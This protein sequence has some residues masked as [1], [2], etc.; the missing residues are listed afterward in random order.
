MVRKE[1]RVTPKE[2]DF[3]NGCRFLQIEEVEDR[4]L[5]GFADGGKA[6]GGEVVVC[7]DLTADFKRH[8]TVGKVIG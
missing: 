6:M 2:K 7:G 1:G 3:A 8:Y 5:S 4:L